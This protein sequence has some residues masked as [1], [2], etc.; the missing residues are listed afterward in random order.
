[1][2][3]MFFDENN[4]VSHKRN[5]RQLKTLK[6]QSTFYREKI[7]ADKKKLE[8]LRSGTKNLEKYAREEFHMTRPDEDLYLIVE[9]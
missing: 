2:W 9:K 5:K 4:L 6:E 3:I 7:E 8:E 1:M